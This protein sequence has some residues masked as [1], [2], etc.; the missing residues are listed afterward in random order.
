MQHAERFNLE[1]VG[2]PSRMRF[3]G[4]WPDRNAPNAAPQKG[5]MKEGK[6]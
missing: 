5:N 3:K 6:G 2:D 1:L 4:S